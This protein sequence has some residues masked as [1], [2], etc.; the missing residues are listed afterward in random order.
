MDFRYLGNE[1]LE[2]SELGLGCAPMSRTNAP[3]DDDEAIRTIHRA[4][5]IGVTMFDTSDV[6]G[7]SHNET[8]LGKA[9][10]GDFKNVVLA[11]KGGST[12]LPD[13]SRG[14]DGKPETAVKS[15]EASLTRLG[16]EVI[17][18]YYLHRIDP[19]VPLEE[20]VG[21]M[22]R[23]VEQGKVRHIGM[24]DLGP[25]EI[26]R[27]YAVHPLTA[28]QSEYSMFVRNV[29]A[30]VLPA[31]RELGISFVCYGPLWRGVLGGTY[32]KEQVVRK[33]VEDLSARR[34][35]WEDRD[36][37]LL[38]PVNDIAAAHGATQA[39]IAIAWLLAQGDDII[40]IPGTR[41]RKYLEENMAAADVALSP[42][43]VATLNS[44]Y[45]V[46]IAKKARK[47]PEPS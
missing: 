6:Y 11:T 34:D 43:E 36:R 3:L 4:R 46:G 12:F 22:A 37:E 14:R 35:L 13:G 23:L 7:A 25:D 32:Y 8:L 9:F 5:E 28:L 41:R 26:R 1:R 2:V 40:P 45:P 39:Q 47:L 29:E 18:L 33:G 15:C 30:E 20:S 38:Q 10:A 16:L 27:A 24:S 44:A 19:D 31:C 17:D 42:Q 21:A